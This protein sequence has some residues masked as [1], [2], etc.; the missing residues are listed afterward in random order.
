MS[1][2]RHEYARWHI[3]RMFFE[4]YKEWQALCEELSIP[5]SIS[6]Q[7]Y[8]DVLYGTN[9]EVE[10][11][12]W[13]SVCKEPGEALLNA[14]TLEV[15]KAYKRNG[16]APVRMD[17]NPAD[18]IGE[19]CRFLEYLT[20]C[21]LHAREAGKQAEADE[22]LETA[23]DFLT[24]FTEDTVRAMQQAADAVE[25]EGY[26][27]PGF[28]FVLGLLTDAI[29]KR[30]WKYGEPDYE[31]WESSS[32]T[33]QDPIPL[34]KAHTVSSTSFYDCGR[35]CKMKT[36]VQEGCVLSIGP[37]KEFKGKEFVGCP[38]G[39]QY[40]NTF[41]ST[42][43]LRYPMLRIG[44][45]GEGRFKRISWEEAARY[46][47][48]AIVETGEKYGPGSR[49]LMPGSGV[50]GVVRGDRFLRDL[51][52]LTGGYLGFYNFY[53][54]SCAVHALPYVYG[55]EVTGNSEEEM[56]NA[57]LIILWGH[58][59]A[60]TIWNDGFLPNLAEAKRKGIRIVV[61]DPRCNETA[62][63]FGDQWIGIRPSTDGAMC[64]AMAY[65]IWSRGLQDQDFM[66]RFCVG[67]DEAHMPEG[68]DPSKCYRA[69]LWGE[70]DGIVKTAEWAQEITGVPAETIR[71]LAI[72]YATAKPACLIPGLG[73]NRTMN[74]EQNCRSF[75]MLACLT[76][77]VGKSGGSA[78]GFQVKHG[79]AE[80][81]YALRVTPYT[82]LIPSFLWTKAVEDWENF[83]RADG[84]MCAEK[85]ETGIKMIF[86]IASGMLINQH[87]NINETIRILTAPGKLD[88][89]IFS[90]LFMTPGARYAD[91]LLPGT[92]FFEM[93]NIIGPWMASDY[94]LF[95][96]KA[97]EP[98]FGSRFEYEWVKMA[99]AILGKEEELTLGR[100]AGDWL[101]CIYEEFRPTEPELPD[102]DTFR[103]AG[104]YAYAHTEREIAFK[105]EIENG[106]PFNTPSG[107]IEIYSARLENSPYKELPG[108]PKYTPCEEGAEDP[109]RERY[110]LQLI[111]YHTNRRCHSVG[112]HNRNLDEVEAPALWMHPAD[113]R[114]RGISQG[115]KVEIYNDRG[116]MVIPVKITERIVNGCVALTEGGWFTPDKKGRDTRGSLNILT[117]SHRGTPLAKANPQHTNLVEVKKLT[118]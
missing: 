88:H 113:A 54:A 63:Q 5:G 114:K 62:V 26:P 32:W 13:A 33:K 52:G 117:F 21:S 28:A 31:K 81:F 102:Y 110:P 59:P 60:N 101:R 44:A 84:L 66:D 46:V 87:S 86:N 3:L 91:L 19:Q 61:I 67:F 64:D 39:H 22:I 104:G 99:A 112:D 53:S 50:C 74:G 1:N 51:L 30:P 14:T 24:A 68:E 97:T 27:L 2:T 36:L 94:L 15:I 80:P 9:A 98:L 48:D 105:K 118:D 41:L 71:N 57:G 111:G 47:A 77:N 40:R 89:L 72:E 42:K 16:Y 93:E 96:Q 106:V 37:D 90:D 79:H 8:E 35:K 49:Y 58:N 23:D 69:Y 25:K 78:G 100:E 6:G 95:N 109:L 82:A 55:T 65:E 75:A 107:K 12:L 34:E 108:I 115:E 83:G 103:A 116:S 7:E 43:R 92:S 11:P 18:Y 29:L 38:R 76:G 56:L 10:I 73:P 45:R 20:A 4:D 70:S 85:L 17:G